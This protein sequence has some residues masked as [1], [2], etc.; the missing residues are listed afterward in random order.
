MLLEISKLI[1]NGILYILRGDSE[2]SFK[3]W[4]QAIHICSVAA[5]NETVESLIQLCI[6][7]WTL[8]VDSYLRFT[9]TIS[10]SKRRYAANLLKNFNAFYMA[11]A[12]YK[13]WLSP[14]TEI[15]SE[16][17][18]NTSDLVQLNME[19]SNEIHEVKN[20]SEMDTAAT[21]QDDR[22]SKIEDTSNSY[23][24]LLTAMGQSGLNVKH[25]QD[26]LVTLSGISF[27][28]LSDLDARVSV[29]KKQLEATEKELMEQEIKQRL[30]EHIESNRTK[31]TK[32]KPHM[33]NNDNIQSEK[34]DTPS[35]SSS[36]GVDSKL[37]SRGDANGYDTS[38]TSL[39]DTSSEVAIVDSGVDV[40]EQTMM[41]LLSKREAIKCEL[42]HIPPEIKVRES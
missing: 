26:L 21:D 19:T 9:E 11:S 35:S 29:L 2:K 41:A 32:S 7:R 18:M 16:S 4:L 12:L 24:K 42:M 30:K 1:A 28:L 25:K 20:Q 33:P 23:A 40:D 22:D 6:P 13:L 31:N 37:I 36:A 39:D 15:E 34:S 38:L 17:N 8:T 10:A 14:D 3:C 5:E 27:S